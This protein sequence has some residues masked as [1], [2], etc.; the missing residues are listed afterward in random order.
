MPLNPFANEKAKIQRKQAI[1][2]QS[3]SV[4]P[5][6]RT[7]FSAALGLCSLYPP[8]SIPVNLTLETS[9]LPCSGP[10]RSRPLSSSPLAH[11]DTQESYL[12]CL[13][14]IG[15]GAGGERPVARSLQKAHASVWGRG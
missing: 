12:G 1:Y 3:H 7:V 8:P 6:F 14:E 13:M 15:G 10:G 11:T 5:V 9:N 2:P 4:L